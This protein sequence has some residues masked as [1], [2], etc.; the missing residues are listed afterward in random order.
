[1]DPKFLA[2]LQ[3]GGRTL[4]D[5]LPNPLPEGLP[6]LTPNLYE[7]AA[8]T[9]ELD[10]VALT[11]KVKEVLLANNLGQKLFGEAVLGLSQG[12]VSEL[13]GKPKAWHTLSI[14]GREP[15]VRMQMWLSDSTSIDKLNAIKKLQEETR[16]RKRPFDENYSGKSSPS[17][18]SDVYSN[19][20]VLEDESVIKKA[21]EN[22]GLDLSFKRDDNEEEDENEEIASKLE[23][24]RSRRKP[25]APQWLNPTWDEAK[26]SS[27][28][29]RENNEGT[30]RT[31]NGVCVVNSSAIFVSD[32]KDD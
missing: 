28:E 11:N 19:P 15:F 29:E 25:L 27:F 2:G 20:G 4:A 5:G 6:H 9:Q 21:R 26:D 10:T 32:A 17:E 7:M 14:K 24:A 13:L 12:S 30:D 18:H 8:L 31:I 16:K 23:A 22:A 3:Q 1:M